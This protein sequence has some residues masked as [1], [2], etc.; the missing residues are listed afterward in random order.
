M[1][2]AVVAPAVR[3]VDRV[4]EQVQ[5]SPGS[6]VSLRAVAT[7]ITRMP[8]KRQL[9]EVDTLR[10]TMRDSMCTTKVRITSVPKCSGVPAVVLA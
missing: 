10:K 2:A 1:A 8:T 7:G 9:I 5:Q 4:R 6:V 3:T